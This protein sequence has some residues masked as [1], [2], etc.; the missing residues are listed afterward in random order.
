MIR[1][2]SVTKGYI[3]ETLFSEASF[4]IGKEERCGIVGRNG[5][6]KT[7]LLRLM[8]GEEHPDAGE[9]YVP[10]QCHIGYL[11]QHIRFSRPTILEEAVLCLPAYRIHEE[12]VAK[13]FSLVSVLQKKIFCVLQIPF[14]AAI[15]SVSI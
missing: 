9:I 10:K 3:G 5:S 7:T 14:L 11:S 4:S 2:S 1:F 15:N 6:G 12:H 8:T 13:K